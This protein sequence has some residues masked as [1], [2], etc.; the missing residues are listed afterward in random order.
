MPG[1]KSDSFNLANFILSIIKSILDL[2]EENI[3]DSP[4][5]SINEPKLKNLAL[6]LLQ[7]NGDSTKKIEITFFCD[8]IK[9][10]ATQLNLII[11]DGGRGEQNLLDYL[12]CSLIDYLDRPLFYHIDFDSDENKRT[13]INDVLLALLKAYKDS[14]F[15]IELSHITGYTL[16]QFTIVFSNIASSTNFAT[17]YETLEFLLDINQ[18]RTSNTE[19]SERKENLCHALPE[20]ITKF[21]EEQVDALVDL[22]NRYDLN[23]VNNII[24][25]NYPPSR[26][27]FQSEYFYSEYSKLK[28]LLI[29]FLDKG[30]NSYD[31]LTHMINALFFYDDADVDADFLDKIEDMILLLINKYRPEDLQL[32]E[33]FSNHLIKITKSFLNEYFRN[34]YDNFESYV[35]FVKFLIKYGA[36]V[37]WQ[38]KDNGYTIF[39]LLFSYHYQYMLEIEHLEF[40]TF[41]YEH[42]F[43]DD[44]VKNKYGHMALDLLPNDVREEIIRNITYCKRRN[45]ILLFESFEITPEEW[46]K[47]SVLKYLFHSDISKEICTFMN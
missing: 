19:D 30:A 28:K 21:T 24:S 44:S 22:L 29:L 34:E 33:R 38:D 43:V 47:S 17:Y 37:N 40:I 31:I 41:L 2:E 27:L 10:C 36:D 23:D 13:A 26:I 39:H 1:K 46:Y 12:L 9:K 15:Q 14:N 45:Y 32:R 20:I 11:F 42:C 18:N 16:Y 7:H 35:L 8:W 4:L 6:E 25:Y 3:Y 5:V